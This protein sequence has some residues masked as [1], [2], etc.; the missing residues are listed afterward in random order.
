MYARKAILPDAE[1]IRALIADFSGGR[2]AVA[3][4]AARRS[5]KTFATLP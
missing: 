5:A 4:V 2:H 3:E 1:N